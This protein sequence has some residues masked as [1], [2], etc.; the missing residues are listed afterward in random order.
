MILVKTY[1]KDN[2]LKEIS[3]K[4]HANYNDYGEDIVCASVSSIALCTVN[5]IYSFGND[6]IKVEEQDG[7]LNI[8]LLKEDKV[9]IRLIENMIRCL[10]DI[11]KDY[12]TN[13]KVK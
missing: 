7:Y 4:G 6:L 13:I 10:K 12:P 2:N 1:M 9:T 3:I 11:E 5:A 8:K